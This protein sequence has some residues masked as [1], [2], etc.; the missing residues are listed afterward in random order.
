VSISRR[1]PK[2]ADL[3]KEGNLLSSAIQEFGE[4]IPELLPPR[5]RLADKLQ[6]IKDLLVETAALQ[7]KKQ[8]AVQK[9]N[10]L[11]EETA[12]LMTHLQSGIKQHYG[13]TSEALS[14]FGMKPFRGLRRPS[15]Q[16]VPPA[17]L[18][19]PDSSQD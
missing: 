13:T 15:R 6:Q 14:G 18:P 7:A 10:L 16:D 19:A 11:Q 12:R 5:D 9:L 8:E 4:E 3:L 1:Y 2:V 17:V